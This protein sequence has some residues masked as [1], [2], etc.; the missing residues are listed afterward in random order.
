MGNKNHLTLIQ[1]WQKK[2]SVGL[3]CL[4]LCIGCSP[5]SSSQDTPIS[6][7]IILYGHSLFT[8]WKTASKDLSP[9]PVSNMAFGGSN[10]AQL[11]EHYSEK[12]LHHKPRLIVLNTGVNYLKSHSVDEFEIALGEL[13][14]LIHLTLP[15]AKVAWLSITN[16]PRAE[17][18]EFRKKQIA[19]TNAAITIIKERDY[20]EVIDMKP[21]I[22]NDKGELIEGYFSKDKVHYN[23]KGYKA[24]TKY[25]K[26]KFEVLWKELQ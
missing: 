8:G 17:G 22:Y 20:V 7:G 11:I 13:L 25:L 6:D 19:A 2:M 16:S 15:D 1:H 24:Y 18:S 9:L 23:K 14:D 26:P 5:N 12:V 21:F 10:T 4:L 3:A